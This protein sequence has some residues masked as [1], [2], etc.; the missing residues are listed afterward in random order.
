MR[1]HPSNSF[2]YPGLPVDLPKGESSRLLAMHGGAKQQQ[3]G[4]VLE[5]Y[6]PMAPKVSI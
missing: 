1:G 2:S 6:R 4:S 5:S 3:S